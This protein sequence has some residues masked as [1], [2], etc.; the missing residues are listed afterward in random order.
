MKK[1]KVR[2]STNEYNNIAYYGDALIVDELP[3]V[4]DNWLPDCELSEEEFIYKIE[5]IWIDPE[6]PKQENWEYDYYCLHYVDIN[7]VC[8]LLNEDEYQD[9]HD[10]C[11]R[12][13]IAIR[14]EEQEDD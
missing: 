3:S 4:G 14:Q 9:V 11:F 5:K 6:Q 13:L 2:L 12:K 10:A 1:I 8:E 7:D